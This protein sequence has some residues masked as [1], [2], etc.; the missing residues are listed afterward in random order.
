[1]ILPPKPIPVGAKRVKAK[2][3]EKGLPLF[4]YQGKQ[5]PMTHYYTLLVIGETGSG[6]TTLL[7]AFVN[8]LTGMEF[9]DDW[10]WKLVN[11]DHLL[12]V[13]GKESQTSE[14]TTYYINDKNNLFNI[15][16]IDTPG[17]GDTKGIKADDS[18]V[19]KF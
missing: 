8:K 19:K 12:G 16:I 2:I 18:T 14:I 6:K 3:Q 15:R 10:R 17:F 1:L 9:I 4:L 13:D 7:D 5:L 11:E